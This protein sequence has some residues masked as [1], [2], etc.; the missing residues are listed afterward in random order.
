[1]I[2][3]YTQAPGRGHITRTAA[4][5]RRQEED[6]FVV[7]Y[8]DWTEALDWA[9]IKHQKS[10]YIPYEVK[11]QATRVLIDGRDYYRLGQCKCEH[12]DDALDMDAFPVILP[13]ENE[14]LSREAAREA[15]GITDERPVMFAL[16]NL[17]NDSIERYL[18]LVEGYNVITTL[19]YPA[20]I[21]FKAADVILGNAGY[22]LYWETKL[23]G[24]PAFLVPADTKTTDQ[25]L[26]VGNKTPS[27]FREFLAT[28]ESN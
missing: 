12:S 3:Y 7:H 11:K 24:V 28:L 5:A 16:T 9:G 21:H 23:I 15:L 22:N 10:R 20:S 17:Y 14:I 19:P 26:R 18:E 25:I 13:L 2:V 27:Q 6:T 1:M 4:L 8:S